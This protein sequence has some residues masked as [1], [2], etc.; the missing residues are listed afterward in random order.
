[1]TSGGC[2]HDHGIIS[3]ISAQDW[4][5]RISWPMV[6]SDN[7]LQNAHLDVSYTA[8]YKTLA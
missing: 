2:L 8:G 5:V 3:D 4:T 6:F 7:P 1:M